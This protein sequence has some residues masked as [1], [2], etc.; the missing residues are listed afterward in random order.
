M[1]V[2]R[3]EEKNADP[4]KNG[5]EKIM[6]NANNDTASTL[7]S[8]YPSL[9]MIALDEKRTD[10][11]KHNTIPRTKTDTIGRLMNNISSKLNIF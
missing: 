2:L 8:R 5:S 3:L 9:T 7:V 11:N 4:K 6:R 10:P 1:L